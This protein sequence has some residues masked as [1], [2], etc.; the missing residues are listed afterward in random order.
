MYTLLHRKPKK[1][2]LYSKELCSLL[3]ASLDGRGLWGRADTHMYMAE[4][5]CRSPETTALVLTGYIPLQNKSLKVQK[6]TRQR[7]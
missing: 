2:L 5:L 6:K 4:S 3:C 7:K 1:D